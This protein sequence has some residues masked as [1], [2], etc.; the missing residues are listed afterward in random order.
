LNK[1]V[2]VPGGDA[3]CTPPERKKEH[4]K[5]APASASGAAVM[6]ELAPAVKHIGFAQN[7]KHRVWRCMLHPNRGTSIGT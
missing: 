6:V 2:E 3:G 1:T 4:R 7:S 5:R